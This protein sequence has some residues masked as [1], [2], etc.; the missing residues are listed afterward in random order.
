VQTAI[1]CHAAPRE[2][3]NIPDKNARIG[4]RYSFGSGVPSMWP[5]QITRKRE[6]SRM[7][8]DSMLLGSTLRRGASPLCRASSAE[9]SGQPGELDVHR[10]RC[11]FGRTKPSSPVLSLV[12]VHL[13]RRSYG[14][15]F[16]SDNPLAIARVRLRNGMPRPSFTTSDPGTE[17]DLPLVSPPKRRRTSAD[18]GQRCSRVWTGARHRHIPDV[19]PMPILQGWR[20]P[21]AA[22]PYSAMTWAGGWQ[23]V[24]DGLV[25]AAAAG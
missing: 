5:A 19:S 24:R 3:P 20:E 22:F 7:R 13:T 10:I 16:W 14:P 6:S 23:R 12:Y 4:G 8:P 17:V 18:T 1:W 11:I 9:S 25:V 2:G 15:P 21:G